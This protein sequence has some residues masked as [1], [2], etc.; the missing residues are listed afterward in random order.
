MAM[1]DPVPERR[2]MR[3]AWATYQPDV[4]IKKICWALN[5]SQALRDRLSSSMPGGGNG[6]LGATVNRDLAQRVRPLTPL[7]R[8]KPVMRQDLVLAAR[9][10]LMLDARLGLWQ[11]SQTSQQ[12]CVPGLKE[13]AISANPLLDGITDHLVDEGGAEEE[14][15]ICRSS[16]HFHMLPESVT[17]H[18]PD[19]SE[20][21]DSVDG[22]NHAPTGSKPV[23]IPSTVVLESDPDLARALDRLIIYLRI[24]HSVD[25]YSASVY[26]MEDAMPHRCGI[27]HAR[28]DRGLNPPGT[29]SGVGS[30]NS[31]S[32]GAASAAI[33]GKQMGG[34]VFTTR[35]VDEYMKNFAAKMSVLLDVPPDLS[36]EEMVELGKRDPERAAEEFIEANILKRTS[37]KKPLV[38]FLA[39][40]AYFSCQTTF[41]PMTNCVKLSSSPIIHYGDNTGKRKIREALDI[42]GEINLMNKRLEEGRVSDNFAYCLSKIEENDKARPA[43]RRCLDKGSAAN[44]GKRD[45]DDERGGQGYSAI[46][47]R[48][49][50]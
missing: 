38:Y 36:E 40:H 24:V 5:T 31:G 48:R 8:H 14:A 41:V 17:S 28:G 12:I 13:P 4:N 23:G 39:C 6:D 34:L 27:L 35:E 15:L 16:F 47:Q 42:L 44:Q 33:S 2:F 3:H 29:A 50:Q 32:V 7:T 26:P 45:C 19:G 20:A 22:S 11:G 30:V 49:C 9:L 37:K 43:K 25:F 1:W 21:V 10:V 46:K 18:A